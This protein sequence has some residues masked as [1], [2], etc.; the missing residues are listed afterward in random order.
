MK[1]EVIW[2]QNSKSGMATATSKYGDEVILLSNRKIGS[3]S[4][5]LVGIDPKKQETTLPASKETKQHRQTLELKPIRDAGDY[6]LITNLIKTELE[7]FKK[8]IRLENNL[9]FSKLV[10]EIFQNFNVSDE[11]KTTLVEDLP[12]NSNR[13]EI[14][15]HICA[16][17]KDALP[18]THDIDFST[19][20]HVICGNYGSGKTSIALRMAV[21][22]IESCEIPPVLVNYKHHKTMETTSVKELSSH[23]GIPVFD[24]DNI[25][26]LKLIEANLSGDGILIVDTATGNI[27][28]SLPVLQ[29]ELE[30]ADFHLV[31]ASDSYA[32][33]Q[34]HLIRAAA[35]TSIMITR[36]DLT[37][38]QPAIMETLIKEKIPLSLGSRSADLRVNLIKITREALAQSTEGLLRQGMSPTYTHH[39]N[40]DSSQIQQPINY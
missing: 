18:Q 20:T 5:L 16:R 17:L 39:A 12:E 27:A 30:S 26:T 14:T 6:Q 31:A 28:E 19:K 29:N 3:R 9:N 13:V 21:K 38:C 1:I 36:L 24:V 2:A 40:R 25:E 23:L 15:A 8:D 11:L 10:N 33:S 22:L 34:Q 35:W 32:S 4:R 7:L 37:P